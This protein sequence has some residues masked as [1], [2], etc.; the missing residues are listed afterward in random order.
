MNAAGAGNA[1]L[2]LEDQRDSLMAQLAELTGAVNTTPAADHRPG[3]GG[4]RHAR[5]GHHQPPAE[6]PASPD[7][8]GDRRRRS[9]A[10]SRLHHHRHPRRA[11]P[12]QPDDHPRLHPA[13]RHPRLRPHRHG[14]PAVCRGHQP[15]RPLHRLDRDEPGQLR[16]RAPL[17]GGAFD[18]AHPGTAHDQRHRQRHRRADGGQHL[19]QPVREPERPRGRD[20]QFRQPHRDRE[21]RGAPKSPPPPATASISPRIRGPISWPPWG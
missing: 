5:D 6:R 11:A 10:G 20:Q 18:R 9:Q 15:E 17:A 8:A 13:A 4:R 3:A 12:A 21:R 1:P 16:E 19:R 14:Q 7:R 2:S